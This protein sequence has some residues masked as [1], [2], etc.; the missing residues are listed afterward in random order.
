[1]STH[2]ARPPHPQHCMLVRSARTGGSSAILRMTGVTPRASLLV[3]LSPSP[4][5][6][7][8]STA[9]SPPSCTSTTFG[10]LP[11]HMAD[12]ILH[13][14][15]GVGEHGRICDDVVGRSFTAHQAH[16]WQNLLIVMRRLAQVCRRAD[17]PVRTCM[18]SCSV[19]R[20][21][22][23]VASLPATPRLTVGHADAPGVPVSDGG[24]VGGRAA[25]GAQRRERR[26]VALRRHLRDT[27]SDR[28]RTEGSWWRST[29]LTDC[30]PAVDNAA[31][32]GDAPSPNACS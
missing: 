14:S 5:S 22:F 23:A 25:A 7:I 4:S 6:S 10:A 26:G 32:G 8:M 11:A 17:C 16:A 31:F 9:P 24:A 1:M 30:P 27:A 15:P 28:R 12:Q 20:N 29:I 2:T 3:G 21:R 19:H 13:S 18:H